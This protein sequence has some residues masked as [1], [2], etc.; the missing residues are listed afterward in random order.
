VYIL[1]CDIHCRSAAECGIRHV[2]VY[3]KWPLTAAAN[4]D[5]SRPCT[6][7][8]HLSEPP[9]AYCLAG[10]ATCKQQTCLPVTIIINYNTAG[11]YLCDAMLARVLAMILC[12]CLCPCLSQVGVLS[13]GMN[14]Q[15]NLL[16]GME[17]SFNQSYTVI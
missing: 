9:H 8:Q 7:D 17:A 16:F 12:L 2:H 10:E 15:V 1:S 13:K 14:E 4:A 11:F 5:C 3:P 6:T